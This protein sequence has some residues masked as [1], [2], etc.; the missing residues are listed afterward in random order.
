MGAEPGVT[1]A[2]ED[3]H[4]YSDNPWETET[5]WFGFYVQEA[6]LTG[7]LY[8]F[9]RPNFGTCSGGVMVWDPAS[10]LPWEAPHFDYQWHLPFP[11][12]QSLLDVTFPTGVSLRCETPFKSHRLTY[13]A[14]GV[15]IDVAFEAVSDPHIPRIGE[16][17][18]GPARHFDQVGRM[19]G[20]LSMRSTVYPIDCLA[21][22]DRSWGPRDDRRV[23]R[24]GYAFGVA[25]TDH[26]FLAYSSPKDATDEVYAGY[27]LRDGQ[28][29]P[30]VSGSRRV[31]RDLNTGGPTTVHIE[32]LDRAGRT[33]VA[34][35]RAINRICVTPYPR[36]VNW[37][38]T[39]LWELDGEEALG[40]DQDGWSVR[41]WSQ[42]RRDNK[43]AGGV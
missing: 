16:P 13:S 27:L 31:W 35:G 25:S 30:L 2:D 10:H 36:M 37:T 6:D 11:E 17:P 29:H 9:I 39:L 14:R 40:E 32:G 24:F 12:G 42:F 23:P 20:S 1:A 33:F 43:G 21:M 8:H 41:A 3:L 15:E 26:A 19:T 7:Y 28:R 5:S 18:F 4:P 38:T 34:T 22:R